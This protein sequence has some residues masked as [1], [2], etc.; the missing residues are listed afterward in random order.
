MLF[1]EISYLQ[2]WLPLCSAEQNHLCNFGR[3]LMRNN[4]SGDVVLKQE[5]PWALG[6]S[7]END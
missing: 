7:P 1:I 6:R 3:G 2:L 5:G 4:G